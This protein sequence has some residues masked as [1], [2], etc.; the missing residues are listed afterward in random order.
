MMER[1]GRNGSYAPRVNRLEGITRGR[2]SPG[3]RPPLYGCGM[4]PPASNVGL[5][6]IRGGS[7]L[8]R[9]PPLSAT[10]PSALAPINF[11]QALLPTGIGGANASRGWNGTYRLVNG[12]DGPTGLAAA[13]REAA[14]SQ[15]GIY[16]SPLAGQ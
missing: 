12:L 11:L 13:W 1:H 14:G 4:L 16:P 9:P 10:P 2:I 8:Y 7:V 6:M 3:Y 15:A 5:G